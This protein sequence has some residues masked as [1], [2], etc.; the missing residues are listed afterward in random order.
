M[1]TGSILL[2]EGS[3]THLAT[4]T[5]TEDAVTKEISRSV[6]NASAGAEIAVATS[7]KQDTIIG[8]LDGVEGLLT[9]IDSDTGSIATTNASI[10]GKITAC[11]TGAVVISSGSVTNS[12]IAAATTSAILQNA[13]SST[14]NGSTLSVAGMSA[15]TFT[16]SGTFVAQ[17][18]FEATEDG[19][20]WASILAKRT[21]STDIQL[22]TLTPGIFE[23]S[24]NGFVSVRARVTW[25][26]GT[27]VTVTAHA[28]A[29]VPAPLL[30]RTMGSGLALASS[31][32]TPIT[33]ATDT[34]VVAAPAAGTHLRI[35]YMHT[36]NSSATVTDTMFRDGAS[37]TRRYRATLPQYGQMAHSTKPDYWD[38]TSATALYLTTSAAGSIHYTVEYTTVPD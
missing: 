19:S 8:H 31:D 7:T 4:N 36:S 17:V 29:A 23:A 32:N 37:G 10:D 13:V 22:A 35:K 38:L 1:A 26:S 20:T 3:T 11:N 2:D 33:T 21:S 5:F 34:L 6:L 18:S 12:A 28:T 15:V 24:V 14:G 27:S 9:T 25:T 30:I 16:V